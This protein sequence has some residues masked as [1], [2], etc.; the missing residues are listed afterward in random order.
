ARGPEER[1]ERGADVLL[2]EVDAV[3]VD[4]VPRGVA[5]GENGGA[6][7]LAVGV[8]RAAGV[9]AHAR[10]GEA[11]QVG[12]RRGARAVGADRVGALLVGGDEEHVHGF[13]PRASPYTVS[14]RRSSML[15]ATS[16]S[17]REALAGLADSGVRP[18]SWQR[19]SAIAQRRPPMPSA[20]AV[21]ARGEV[22]GRV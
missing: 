4:A 20:R 6:R 11:V 1:G 19:P 12:R 2:R 16:P 7:G 14:G 21:T 22:H 10:G 13:M 9:E 5:P 8:L 17:A 18:F 3:R 15:T